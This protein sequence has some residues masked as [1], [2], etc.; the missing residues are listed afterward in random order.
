MKT[1]SRKVLEDDKPMCTLDCSKY[2]DK[3][4]PDLNIDLYEMLVRHQNGDITTLGGMIRTDAQYSTKEDIEQMR[5][6]LD[7]DPEFNLLTAKL[8]AQRQ[9]MELQRAIEDE[10]ID[11][12]KKNA[13]STEPKNGDSPSA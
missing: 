7:N 6:A 1:F 10:S 11:Y 4:V 9:E 8:Y 3:C 2:P 13:S 12:A 5:V